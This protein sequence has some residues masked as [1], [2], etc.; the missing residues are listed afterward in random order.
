M[1]STHWINF[2]TGHILVFTYLKPVRKITIH[3]PHK[4]QQQKCGQQSQSKKSQEGCL[5]EKASDVIQ[6]PS[7]Y[8]FLQSA[9]CIRT[10]ANINFKNKPRSTGRATKVIFCCFLCYVMLCKLH[11]T[12]IWMQDL[13][14]QA[15]WQ[16]FHVKIYFKSLKGL[17]NCG[18]SML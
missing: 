5:A 6:L 14:D 10:R 11:K 3:R 2:I 9:A 1:C 13:S 8:N 16:G 15:G 12:T 18:E 7:W 4:T 17:N